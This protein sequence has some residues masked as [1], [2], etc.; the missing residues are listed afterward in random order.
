MISRGVDTRLYS[1]A[2]RSADLRRQ[3]GVGP[4]A[5]AVVCVGRIAAEKNLGLALRAFAAIRQQRPDARMVLVGDGPMRAGIARE[6]PDVVQA[7][8]RHGE[9]LAAH[10]ASGDLFLFPSLTET[11]GNV[12]LEAMASGLCV[13][14]YDYAAAAEVIADLGNGAVV[15]CGDEQG[16]V[17]RALQLALADTLRAELGVQARQTAI[18]IDWEAVNDHFSAALLRAWEGHRRSKVPATD[19]RAREVQG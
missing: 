2:R 19:L 17:E 4:D 11:F 6:H 9:D 13:L 18:G 12:T 7:G 5:L 14:A 16:F 10:Y 1:P 15:R 8:M 3:W